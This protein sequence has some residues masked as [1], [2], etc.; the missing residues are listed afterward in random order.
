MVTRRLLVRPVCG[1][2]VGPRESWGGDDEFHSGDGPTNGRRR[3]RSVGHGRHGRIGVIP[4][5]HRRAVAPVSHPVG[6]G[7]RGLVAVLLRGPRAGRR[8]PRGPHRQAVDGPGDPPGPDPAER[9]CDRLE[10]CRDRCNHGGDPTHGRPRRPFWA[11]ARPAPGRKLAHV[12][13]RV[14]AVRRVDVDLG[15]GRYLRG[16]SDAGNCGAHARR[17]GHGVGDRGMAGAY[18]RGAVDPRARAGLYH[19]VG[20]RDMRVV[21]G[22]LSRAERRARIGRR[23][24]RQAVDSRHRCLLGGRVSRAFHAAIPGWPRPHVRGHGGHGGGVGSIQPHCKA[25][26]NLT[27]F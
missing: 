2:D 13:A 16:R 9:A 5:H 12:R 3:G 24:H 23:P 4:R 19:R 20:C 22:V 27:L 25:R 15:Q 11:A 26:T 21:V 14:R 17:A 1:A 7:H 6:P 10:C 18:S 8:I